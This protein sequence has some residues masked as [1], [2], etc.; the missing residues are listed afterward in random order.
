MTNSK[1]QFNP[2]WDNRILDF[3]GEDHVCIGRVARNSLKA[4]A[5]ISYELNKVSVSATIINDE[6]WVPLEQAY[7]A[8]EALKRNPMFCQ[9][10]MTGDWSVDAP[11]PADKNDLRIGMD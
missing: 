11:V 7:Y 9:I 1:I 10:S 2:E 8:M 6:I 4:Q 3:C 5:Y